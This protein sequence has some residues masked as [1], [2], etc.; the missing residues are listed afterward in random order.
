MLS[1]NLKTL[2]WRNSYIS[3]HKQQKKGKKQKTQVFELVYYYFSNTPVDDAKLLI[4]KLSL[5]YLFF[6]QTVNLI[7]RVWHT[8]W[9]MVDLNSIYLVNELISPSPVFQKKC[10]ADL[11][12]LLR[13]WPVEQ[14]DM[15]ITSFSHSQN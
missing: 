2:I 12:R 3:K 14:T 5:V 7:Y 1:D 4:C 11:F 10:K 15:M 8:S 13:N 9:N 6:N